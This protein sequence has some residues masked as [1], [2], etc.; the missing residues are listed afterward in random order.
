M[1]LLLLPIDASHPNFV[2]YSD[3]YYGSTNNSCSKNNIDHSVLLRGYFGMWKIR[4][5]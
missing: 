5:K 1:D 3:G 2:S 4:F